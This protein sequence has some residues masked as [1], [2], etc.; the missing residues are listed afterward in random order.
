M[1][2]NTQ[3][4]IILFSILPFILGLLT[5]V[6]LAREAFIDSCTSL[7]IVIVRDSIYSCQ[8]IPSVLSTFRFFT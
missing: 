7:G 3:K 6:Y 5:G 8:K 1:L 4:L 2:T